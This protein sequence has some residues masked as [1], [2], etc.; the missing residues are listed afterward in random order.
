MDVHLFHKTTELVD[1]TK[2]K[3]MRKATRKKLERLGEIQSYK[4]S[5]VLNFP[6]YR[7]R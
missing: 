2:V 1:I 5:V 4:H 3:R 7:L 6:F